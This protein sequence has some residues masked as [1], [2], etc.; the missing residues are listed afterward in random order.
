MTPAAAISM[1][2]R[3]IRE[4]GQ[5][6]VLRRP[7]ANG[8]AIERPARAFVRGYRPDELT[9]GLQQGDTQVVLSPTGMPAEFADADATRLRKLD[10]I[11]FDGR[12]RT[13]KFVE[14]V[15]VG[16]ALVRLNV[17]VEG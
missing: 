7:V 13:V 11:I 12:T 10:R 5:N 2:D 15:R 9:G 17:T 1:L 4:H 8:A 6:I 16:G 3:Q 14:P